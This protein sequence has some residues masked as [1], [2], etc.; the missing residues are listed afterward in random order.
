M[1]WSFSRVSPALS[2]LSKPMVVLRAESWKP[3]YPTTNTKL[4]TTRSHVF[5]D[6]SGM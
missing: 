5:W 2:S 6:I 4:A 3:K 1:S